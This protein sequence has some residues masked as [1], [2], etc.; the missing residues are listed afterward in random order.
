MLDYNDIFDEVA[1]DKREDYEIAFLLGQYTIQEIATE[2]E[3]NSTIV[4]THMKR[5]IAKE[6][7][8]KIVQFLPSTA[9]Q[10]AELLIQVKAKALDMLRQE[11]ELDDRDI[12]LL[13]TLI[14]SSSKYLEKYGQ[15]TEGIGGV[16]QPITFNYFEVACKEI[17]SNH[18]TVYMEIKKRMVELE[19]GIDYEV[20]Q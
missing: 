9:S 7:R 13:N 4:A 15:V 8:E 6:T 20:K 17:L 16:N 12:R 2:L 11:D 1:G 5:R 14:N 19:K 18:P 10:C 3:L